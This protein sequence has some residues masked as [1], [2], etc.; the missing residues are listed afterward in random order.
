MKDKTKTIIKSIVAF[1]IFVGII[2]G[3]TNIDNTEDVQL[4]EDSVVTDDFGTTA[5][6]SVSPT[7]SGHGTNKPYVEAETSVAEK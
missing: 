5:V 2:F 6:G 3:I 7:S 4:I 1:L